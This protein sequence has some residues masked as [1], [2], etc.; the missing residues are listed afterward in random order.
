MIAPKVNKYVD[1]KCAHEAGY[2]SYI[3][4]LVFAAMCNFLGAQEKTEKIEKEEVKG[5]EVIKGSKKKS[6]K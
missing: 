2:D 5:G 1:G 4:G 3:T 6:S